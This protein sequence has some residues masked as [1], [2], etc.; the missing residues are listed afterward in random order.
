VRLLASHQFGSIDSVAASLGPD[1]IKPTEAQKA[2]RPLSKPTV[3]LA[4]RRRNLQLQSVRSPECL[5][6]S[7][8]TTSKPFKKTKKP[9]ES[10]GFVSIC[11]LLA[12]AGFSLG[13][14][15][16]GLELLRKTPGKTTILIVEGSKAGPKAIQTRPKSLRCGPP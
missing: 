8:N 3:G 12:D 5:R 16:I 13:I 14:G 7:A 1:G 15:D 2:R 4:R 11:R 6:T 10:L 9:K